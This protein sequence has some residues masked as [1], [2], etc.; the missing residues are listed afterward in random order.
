MKK[1]ILHEKTRIALVAIFIGIVAIFL[2]GFIY[3]KPAYARGSVKVYSINEMLDIKFVSASTN[4]PDKN[5]DPGQNQHVGQC[6]ATLHDNLVDFKFFNG[7]PG[8]QCTLSASF[9]NMSDQAIRLQR[10]A[11]TVPEELFI[12]QP[13][14]PSGLLLQPGE[15]ASMDIDLEICQNAEEWAKYQFSIELI[16]EASNE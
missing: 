1:N 7:Y 3:A 12:S 13:D 4:D 8:Y 2:L 9:K 11:A 5:I 14:L 16:F 10:V 15:G 6:T